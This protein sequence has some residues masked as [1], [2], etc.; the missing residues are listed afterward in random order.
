MLIACFI[1]PYEFLGLLTKILARG[2]VGQ[3]RPRLY[4]F[5]L[6]SIRKSRSPRVDLGG[7]PYPGA[8]RLPFSLERGRTRGIPA[9]HS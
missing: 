8:W 3:R 9:V 2:L 7:L 6:L 1:L 5:P 4:V